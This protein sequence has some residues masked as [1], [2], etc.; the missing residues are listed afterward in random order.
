MNQPQR[1]DAGVH[2]PETHRERVL[3]ER[4]FFRTAG[5][6]LI[7]G[8]GVRLLRDARENFPAWLEAIRAAE[9]SV[10]LECYII[11]ND[12]VGREFV[13]ALAD[14]AAQGVRVR[15]VYDWLG[16]RGFG[17]LHRRLALAGAQ[18]RCFNPPRLDSPLGW[19]SRDHRKMIIVDGRIGFVTGL[20]VSAKWLG[21]PAK[22]LDPWR[23]TGVELR[24]PAVADLERAFADVWRVIGPDPLP[25]TELTPPEYT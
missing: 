11:D 9:R 15:V 4:A 21:D 14:K 2:P 8:N 13:E 16:S 25:A 1:A 6:P 12:A 17:P 20:C 24:G 22:R 23:D 10:T 3:A 7:L 19:L 5:A 18:V